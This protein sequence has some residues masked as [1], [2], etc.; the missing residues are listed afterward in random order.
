MDNNQ[1]DLFTYQLQFQQH[2][3][4]PGK[5]DSGYLQGDQLQLQASS[6]QNNISLAA[7]DKQNNPVSPMFLYDFANVTTLSDK[8]DSSMQQKDNSAFDKSN[9]YQEL[10]FSS[11]NNQNNAK[12]RNYSSSIPINQTKNNYIN[13]NQTGL[14]ASPFEFDNDTVNLASSLNSKS[15]FL[16]AQ[17]QIND[18]INM[19]AP[20]LDENT[21][22]S[23]ESSLRNNALTP[24]YNDFGFYSNNPTSGIEIQKPND[25]L[26]AGMPMAQHQR[27]IEMQNFG[28]SSPINTSYYSS[29]LPSTSQ[30]DRNSSIFEAHGLQKVMEDS[31]YFAN[32]NMIKDG[33]AIYSPSSALNGSIDFKESGN[34]IARTNILHEKRR[35]R[36]ESH[37]AVERRRRDNI[38]DQITELYNLLPNHMKDPNI[39][40]NKGLI[41][42]KSVAYIK[43]LK[44]INLNKNANSADF[45]S[46]GISSNH[47]HNTTGSGL[48][49]ILSSKQTAGS[50]SNTS[51]SV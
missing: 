39:K 22:F 26:I 43:E 36:R 19:F 40:P 44:G 20:L 41:L 2:S 37:N 8:H 12:I 49:S 34:G 50:T 32:S 35:R 31:P 18:K 51:P 48:A 1:A 6:A 4:I 23:P 30:W 25:S 28:A 29:S 15:Q 7:P 42:S 10:L 13:N 24:N 47:T 16:G 17:V 9:L 46:S 14:F 3:D 27:F 45:Y 5:K 33:G 21:D 38:N 11:L